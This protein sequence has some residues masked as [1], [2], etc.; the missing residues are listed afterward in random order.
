MMILASVFYG[1]LV[2]E[3]ANMEVSEWPG[4]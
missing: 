1:A 4:E 2:A 3:F